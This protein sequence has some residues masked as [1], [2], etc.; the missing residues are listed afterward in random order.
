MDQHLKINKYNTACK[1]IQE[2]KS[3]NNFNRCRKRSEKIQHSLIIKVLKKLEIE[4]MYLN[5]IKPHMT[6]P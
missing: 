3:H 6:N 1:Y 4:G 2:Q 5:V